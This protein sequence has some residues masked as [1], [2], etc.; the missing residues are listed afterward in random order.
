MTRE[1]I[2]LCIGAERARQDSERGGCAHDMK[3]SKLDWTAIIQEHTRKVL[4]E[5]AY[6]RELIHIA[7]LAVAALEVASASRGD[8]APR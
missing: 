7:A 3:H 8:E 4:Y 2:L 6:Q 1:E 5:G